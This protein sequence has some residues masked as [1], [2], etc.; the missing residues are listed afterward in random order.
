MAAALADGGGRSGGDRFSPL[1]LLWLPEAP[2][3]GAPPLPVAAVFGGEQP[4][5]ALRTAWESTAT[6]LAVK[7]GTPAA[8]HGHM[9][10]GSFVFDAHGQRWVHD[11]GSDDYNMPGYFGGQRW[12]YFRLN[13][14]SHNTLVIDGKLQNPKSPPCPVTRRERD[15][16]WSTVAFDLSKAYQGQAAAVRRTV[17]FDHAAGVAVMT[18]EIEAPAGAVRWAVVTDAEV[19]LAGQDALLRKRGKQI[20]LRRVD[21]SGGD[22]QLADATA[23]TPRERSNKGF[24]ILSFTA[25]RSDSLRLEVGLRP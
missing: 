22:W 20:T 23:P 2:K 10:V 5:A 18:D 19:T 4:V 12:D 15:G 14:L 13:S 8:S 1:H 24:R 7:G 11:L 25:P 9:D 6:W 3:Q 16:N 17:R 21:R